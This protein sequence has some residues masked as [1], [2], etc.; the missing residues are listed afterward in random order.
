MGYSAFGPWVDF[1]YIHAEHTLDKKSVMV[2]FSKHNKLTATNEAG[3]K[4]IVK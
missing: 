1:P 4:I 2:R 3:R